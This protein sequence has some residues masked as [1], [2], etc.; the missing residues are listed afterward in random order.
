MIATATS[1]IIQMRTY[2]EQENG[3]ALR[4]GG[5][6]VAAATP[7]PAPAPAITGTRS[8]DL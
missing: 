8:D 5:D 4:S 1:Q 6:V 2:M 3:A 7:V